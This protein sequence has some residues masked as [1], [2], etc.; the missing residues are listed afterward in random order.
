M[1]DL[2]AE[3]FDPEFH[4]VSVYETAAGWTAEILFH[5]ETERGLIEAVVERGA[6]RLGAEA[7][8]FSTIATRDWV[9]A[10]LEGL[11][12]VVAGRFVMH[13]SHNRGRVRPNQLGIEI[14]A[15]LAF[16]TGHH[17][18]TRGCL[19]AF[20][21]LLKRARSPHSWCILDIG[22]GTGVLAIAAARA[23]HIRILASDIDPA[24]VAVARENARHN[25]AAALVSVFTAAGVEARRLRSGGP[26]DLIFANIL[27]GPLRR[28]SA[29]TAPLLA[30]AGRI[31]L[32]GLLPIHANG[33]IAA[34]RRQGLALESRLTLEGWTTLTMR[35]GPKAQRP[36]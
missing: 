6:G 14:E 30:P 13:G 20:E 35:R 24:A 36:G 33:V 7:L 28:M 16:G 31:V 17:G 19:L 25:H 11:A 34:Y 29:R 8:T 32:S 27:E 3:A 23:L 2:F 5:A 18:T 1:A 4:A 10:S 9:A 12:P 26:Y 21:R 22:T 15:A